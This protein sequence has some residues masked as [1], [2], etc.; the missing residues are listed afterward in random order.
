MPCKAACNA[1][2]P[3]IST[4]M[5]RGRISSASSNPPRLSPTVSAAPTAPSRLNTGVPSSSDSISTGTQCPGNPSIKASTGATSTS[6]SPEKTQCA[7]TL[8]RTRRAKGCG[9]RTHCSSDPSSKS[10]RNSPSSE[11]STAN[12]AATQ[13]SP[14][15]KVCNNCV[16]GP[17]ASGN[18]A[19]TIAKNTS[20]L[21]SSAG[22]RAS[23]RASRCSNRMNTLLMPVCFP[24]P[25]VDNR[26]A[27]G[28]AHDEWSA[29][30][31]RPAHSVQ[32]DRLPA[33]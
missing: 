18:N 25:V 13:T 9:E 27:L 30:R 12:S 19:I 21:A 11:S 15:D 24:D 28:P 5:Y 8:T 6:A 2:L 10:L 22:R 29:P 23:S 20:G 14:G 31:R 7:S 26:Q 17:T 16:S 3:R 33:D 32:S 1:P 4:G